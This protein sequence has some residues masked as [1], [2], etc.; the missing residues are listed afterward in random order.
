MVSHY[1]GSDTFLFFNYSTYLTYLIFPS[2]KLIHRNLKSQ[3]KSNGL[4]LIWVS[5]FAPQPATTQVAIILF[6]LHTELYTSTSY[7]FFNANFIKCILENLGFTYKGFFHSLLF[8]EQDVRKVINIQLQGP[9]LTPMVTKRSQN[10]DWY[11]SF[12][13]SIVKGLIQF[14]CTL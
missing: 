8:N 11:C 2:H 1:K 3:E 5:K 9:T 14:N 10:P 6:L 7:M 4:Q 13:F 12:T